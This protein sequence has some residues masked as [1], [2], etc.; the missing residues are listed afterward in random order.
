MARVFPGHPDYLLLSA[1]MPCHEFQKLYCRYVTTM[2]RRL[3]IEHLVDMDEFQHSYPRHRRHHRQLTMLLEQ[4][5]AALLTTDPCSRLL[6]LHVRMHILNNIMTAT[7]HDIQTILH[8]LTTYPGD[9][10][11]MESLH[12]E[13]AYLESR[14]RRDQEDHS[15]IQQQI[16]TAAQDTRQ[17]VLPM[18]RV[19]VDAIRPDPASPSPL[20]HRNLFD[21]SPPSYPRFPS[22]DNATS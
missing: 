8:Y 16:Q 14:L 19:M 10:N 5:R 13:I 18:D 12:Q 9:I 22:S 11:G 2:S 6:Q 15:S 3:S 20:R 1:T 4:M 7:E 21:R 17:I